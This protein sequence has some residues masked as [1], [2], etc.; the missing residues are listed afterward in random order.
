MARGGKIVGVAVLVIVAALL[1]GITFTIGW[2]PFLGPRIRPATQRTFD[3]TPGRLA[4][5]EYLANAVS[6]CIF[7]HS[8][9]DFTQRGFPT[10]A[11][12]AG[13]GMVFPLKDLPGQLTAPNLTADPET[14][15]GRWTDDE[16]AR[17]IREGVDRGGR[18]LFPLMPYEHFRHMSDEDLASVVVYLRSLPPVRSTLPA[19][20]IIF[21]VSYLIRALPQPVVSA[22]PPAD[23][24]T[25]VE[26]GAYLAEMAGCTDCH[27][28]QK[29]GA[30]L[31][32][33][34][35]GGGFVLEGPWGRVASANIT[36]DPSG[37]PYYDAQLFVQVMR[38]GYVKA[39]P[40]NSIMPWPAYRDMTDEN[41]RDLFAY[42]Q[43]LKP[44][45]HHVDNTEPPT[46][47]RICNT[48]HGAGA[49][50]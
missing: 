11:G 39:R 9:H 20:H 10:A 7:C 30:P 2:R 16:I 42:L 44:V 33:L 18:S 37:I 6:G 24:S 13:A 22:V 3:R 35:F 47:C 49:T 31:Q 43:T 17:A 23:S 14:G 27:T 1:V 32:G 21:P 8:D 12:R 34:E 28:P 50:N 45:R 46:L 48:S 29:N 5:G 26:R 15:L 4:R 41:L 25:P 38:T 40:L 19:T 36:P